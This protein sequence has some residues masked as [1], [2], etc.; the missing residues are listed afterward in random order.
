[1]RTDYPD[2]RLHGRLMQ[3]LNKRRGHRLANTVEQA[4]IAASTGD[5][6]APMPL[7]WTRAWC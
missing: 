6:E 5:A 4:K 1:M 2:A 7:D 3:V